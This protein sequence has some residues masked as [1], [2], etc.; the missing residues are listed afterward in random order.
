LSLVGILTQE[1]MSFRFSA[2]TLL[3][4]INLFFG[5]DEDVSSRL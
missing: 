3:G 4:F 5:E 2:N 1:E